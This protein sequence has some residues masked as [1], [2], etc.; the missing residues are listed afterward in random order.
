MDVAFS[1]QIGLLLMPLG[2]VW[3][4]W[5]MRIV[6]TPR[7]MPYFYLGAA[8]YA[9]S[10]FI[11]ILGGF[12]VWSYVAVTVVNGLG[13]GFAFEGIMKVWTQES[14]PTLLRTT[15]QGA[16]ISVARV[17]AAVLAEPASIGRVIPFRD[18]ETPIAQAVAIAPPESGLR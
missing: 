2:F 1:S 6:D 13:S 16:I 7:R 15:A 18:G 5:F 3:G 11:Y 9:G 14:F 4:I 12:H 8:C 17:I 10:Y